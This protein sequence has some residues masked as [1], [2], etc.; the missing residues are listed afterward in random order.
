MLGTLLSRRKFRPYGIERVA[1]AKTYQFWIGDA[2]GEQW[3]APQEAGD[4]HHVDSELIETTFVLEHML[5]KDDLVFECGAHHGWNTIQLAEGLV[6]AGGGQLVSF[7]PNRGNFEIL[8][9]NVALNR[10]EN[11]TSSKPPWAPRLAR[12]AFIR[13]RTAPSCQVYCR[14]PSS[15]GG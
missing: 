10:Y 2:E 7:E 14:A 9:K 8:S 15:R 5:A 11:V 4:Q 1:Q 3:Y 6:R 13:S 12:C